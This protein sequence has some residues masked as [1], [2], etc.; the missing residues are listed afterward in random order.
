M[1]AEGFWDDSERAAAVSAEHA[2]TSRRLEAFRQLE[3][4]VDDL[5]GLAEMAAEDASVQEEVDEQ[6]ASVESRLAALEEQRLFSGPYDAGDALGGEPGLRGGAAR[7]WRGRGSGDQVV[8]VPRI[9]RERLRAVRRRAR[10]AQARATLAVRLRAP[11]PD[12]LRGL[13]GGAGGAGHGRGGDQRGRPA[14]GHLPRLGRGWPARQQDGLRGAH[15]APPHGHRGAV[16][17]RA[18]AVLQ[19]GDRDGDAAR[20]DARAQG[21]RTPGG[22][23]AREGGGPG[24]ELRIADP[25]LRAAPLHDGQGPSHSPRDGRRRASP[26]RRP[27][28]IRAFVS[29]H[30]GRLGRI[31]VDALTALVQRALAEDVGSGDVTTLATVPADARARAL[32][33]QKEPGAVYGLEA[34]ERT[35]AQLDGDARM[36]RL[37]EEGVWR[38]QGGGVLAVEGSAQALL[39]G[40]RTALNFL[41]HLS[42]VATMAARAARAPPSW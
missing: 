32:I 4:D 14:G 2:R 8:D 25:L 6:I 39:T 24:R 7:G 28:W 3:A 18:L 19:P 37:V 21:A 5:D 12:E 41:A 29:A 1:G 20:E 38:E 31:A 13:G 36:E 15:H 30:R 33:T 35:F 23:R 27:R 10:R 9:G 40:E 17:E 34:A 16:P 22:D 11:P 26:R 42:G